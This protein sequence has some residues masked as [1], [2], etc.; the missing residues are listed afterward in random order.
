MKKT[1]KWLPRVLAIAY[2]LFISIFALDAFSEEYTLLE[3]IVGFLVHL[4]PSFILVIITLI[5]WK[6]EFTGGILFIISGVGFTLFFNTYRE[7]ISF[8]LISI[9]LIVIGLLFIISG[10]SRKS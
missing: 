5:A 4:L 9:P 10:K 8:V 1:M 2:I 6:K 3:M 7:L